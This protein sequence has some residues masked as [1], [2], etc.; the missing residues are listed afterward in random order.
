MERSDRGLAKLG[1]FLPRYLYALLCSFYLFSFGVLK[2]RL[3]IYRICEHFGWPSPDWLERPRQ[4]LPEATAGSISSDEAVRVFEDRT[5]GNMSFLETI[6]ISKMVKHYQPQRMFEIGTFD[7]RTTLHLAAN[8]TES[9]HIFTLDLPQSQ[10]SATAL[11][12]SEGDKKFIQKPESGTRFKGTDEER[13]ITQL[14]GDS[15]SFDFSPF[16]ETIDLVLV[17]GSHAYDYA[18]ND[19]Q[20]AMKL[21]NKKN[22]IILWHDYGEWDGVTQA[23]NEL[24]ANDKRFSALRR[25]RG[26]TLAFLRLATAC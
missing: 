19:S 24:Y 12:V 8:A 2:H 20:V 18:L 26:T 3:L 14:F 23:L 10:V 1:R 16:N 17:D 4:I 7:G 11:P 22:G 25:I 21:I 9:A 6:V 15:A 13:K 5:D